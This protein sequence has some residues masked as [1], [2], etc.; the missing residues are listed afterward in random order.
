MRCVRNRTHTEQPSKPTLFPFC[1]SSHHHRS[2]CIEWRYRDMEGREGERERKRPWQPCFTTQEAYPTPAGGDE[3]VEP[4]SLCPATCSLSQV[5][6]CPTPSFCLSLREREQRHYARLHCPWCSRV[7]SGPRPRATQEA[8]PVFSHLAAGVFILK[9][10]RDFRLEQ[11]WAACVCRDRLEI[12]NVT[13]V[14]Q[15]GQLRH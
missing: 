10:A 2:V 9:Q 15:N 11:G 14:V 5:H 7:A 4:G 6:P 8:G 13:Q 12:H 1:I 3:G